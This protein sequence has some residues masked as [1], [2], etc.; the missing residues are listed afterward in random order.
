MQVYLYNEYCTSA[1]KPFRGT[2]EEA[3]ETDDAFLYDEGTREEIIKGALESLATR[4]DH[5]AGGGGDRFRWKCDRNVL[6]L[7]DGPEV[8][9]DQ[10]SMTYRVP[11]DEEE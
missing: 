4:H 1:G 8:E 6:W 10:E 2:D 9:F 7:L 5:R 11:A 3:A